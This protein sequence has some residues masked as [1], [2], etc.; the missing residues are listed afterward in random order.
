MIWAGK[1]ASVEEIAGL[2]LGQSLSQA[3]GIMIFLGLNSALSTQI[4]QAYG[5]SQSSGVCNSESALK[6]C[7]HYVNQA[8]IQNW[9]LFIP[10]GLMLANMQFFFELIG[11]DSTV[12]MYA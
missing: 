2:G 6:L 9:V 10:I 4:S 1:Y 11:Q 3:L 5:L 8:Y 7:G 12:A